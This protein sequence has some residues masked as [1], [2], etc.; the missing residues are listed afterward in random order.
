MK[1]KNEKLPVPRGYVSIYNAY[2]GERLV[3]KHNIVVA[4]ARFSIL[5]AL[6]G[7]DAGH[8]TQ[9][10][11]GFDFVS[12]W[13]ASGRL[14]TTDTY[15]GRKILVNSDPT[16]LFQGTNSYI[17]VG[18]EFREVASFTTTHIF[19]VQP[20][21][22]PMNNTPFDYYS[23]NFSESNPEP[24]TIG[25]DE[26]VMDV[27]YDSKLALVDTS[28]DFLLSNTTPAKLSISHEVHGTDLMNQ[29]AGKAFLNLYSCALHT[30]DGKVFSYLRIPR[31][32]VTAT[33]TLK[34]VWTLEF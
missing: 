34:V 15:D 12:N 24:A 17:R 30:E 6:M 25:Y 32:G 11:M 21:D 29:N 2:T 16:T 28:L 23:G 33:I 7:D 10:K 18:N 26:S 19:L 5:K 14:G 1:I 4:D 13:P 3:D 31:L 8:I 20:F 9:L 22:V 27:G